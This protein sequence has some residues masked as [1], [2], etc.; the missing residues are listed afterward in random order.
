[1]RTLKHGAKFLL[2]AVVFVLILL[3]FYHCPFHMLFG[4]PCPGCGMTRALITALKGDFVS[5]FLYHPLWPLLLPVG[6]YAAL[7]FFEHLSVPMHRQ[8]VYLILFAGIMILVYTVR[9]AVGD[10]IVNID[11][12]SSVFGRLLQMLCTE[13][14]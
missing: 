5:A 12:E 9:L 1:M 11:F 3:L 2:L 10:P 8:N 7:L 14:K 4:V 6:I 13:W